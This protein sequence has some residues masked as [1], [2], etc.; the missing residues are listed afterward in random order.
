MFDV[1]F[2]GGAIL[3][4][5]FLVVFCILMADGGTRAMAARGPRRRGKTAWLTIVALSIGTAVIMSSLGVGDALKGLVIARADLNLSGVDV[6]VISAD[7]IDAGHIDELRADPQVASLCKDLEPAFVLPVVLHNNV[8]GRTTARAILYAFDPQMGDRLGTFHWA[9]NGSDKSGMPLSDGQVVLNSK[10]AKEVDAFRH[11]D[12]YIG[13]D[14]PALRKETMFTDPGVDHVTMPIGQI[15]D[16][17]GLGRF[18]FNVQD[19]QPAAYMTLHTVR[20]ALKVGNKMNAVLVS[21]KEADEANNAKI[22]IE[23]ALDASLQAPDLHLKVATVPGDKAI[24]SHVQVSSDRVFFKES[25]LTGLDGQRSLISTYFVDTLSVEHSKGSVSY[26]SY[27]TVTGLVPS[28]DANFG[29]FTQNGTH[30]QFSGDLQTG[31]IGITNWTAAM[32]GAKVGDT[33]II[34]YSI[35]DD[36]FDLIKHNRSFTV[37]WVVDMVGKANDTNLMPNFPGIGGIESCF[38]WNPPFPIDLSSIQPQDESY[39]KQFKG[40]P[41]AY[42]LLPDA[43][44][45]WGN[46]QGNVTMVKTVQT[47]NIVS[48]FLDT[49]ATTATVGMSVAALRDQLVRSA[50]AMDIF[51]QMFL[52]FGAITIAAAIIFVASTFRMMVDERK[53]E[54]GMMR[55]LGISRNRI[56][57]DM[58]AEGLLYSL[59]GGLLGLVFGLI[60]AGSLLVG[61]QTVWTSVVGGQQVAAQ[62]FVPIFMTA[63]TLAMS[64]GAGLLLSLVCLAVLA[65]TGSRMTIMESRGHTNDT[66]KPND[67]L[68]MALVGIVVVLFI[69]I[70]IAPFVIPGKTLAF[71]LELKILI[72]MTWVGAFFFWAK[73]KSVDRPRKKRSLFQGNGMVFVMGLGLVATVISIISAAGEFSNPPISVLALFVLDGLLITGSLFLVFVPILWLLPKAPTRTSQIVALSFMKRNGKRTAMTIGVFALIIF[74]IISLSVIIQ[75]EN[76]A[77][78]SSAKQQGGGFDVMA[79]ATRPIGPDLNDK[80][81]RAKLGVNLTVPADFYMVRTVGTSG[82]VCSNMNPQ[83]PPRLMGVDDRFVNASSLSLTSSSFSGNDKAKWGSLKTKVDGRIPIF[84]D[85][86]TLI[87]Y[88]GYA[89]YEGALGHVFKVDT[90]KGQAELVVAGILS[91]SIIAGNFV[92]HEDYLKQLYPT[93]SGYRVVFVKTP[94]K[95]ALI[96]ELEKGLANFGLDARSV[97]DIVRES[98]SAE[99][100]YMNLFQA[101]LGAGLGL[102]VVALAVTQARE[103]VERRRDIAMLKAIGLSRTSI[104][105]VFYIEAAFVGLISLGIGLIAGLALAFTSGPAWGLSAGA[106]VV[107]PYQFM[108]LFSAGLMGILLLAT[109]VP[110]TRASRLSPVSVLKEE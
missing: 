43:E 59:I 8:S 110:A 69:L 19:V 77:L 104:G 91:P 90:E 34:T 20:D 62:A 70:L 5:I 56:F 49:K 28:D 52:A 14:S 93:G 31:Q 22:A 12:L 48:G 58:L 53:A 50:S 32:L 44:A 108:V 23:T 47:A 102:G 83:Y 3:I 80:A 29:A 71:S 38:K 4:A 21:L 97:E 9:D 51:L 45:M 106:M 46:D 18:Q 101:Y 33:L 76:S 73:G 17:D 75:V 57:K 42:I 40:I 27:S 54:L 89:A 98:T 96:S 64:L 107:L 67:P 87:I 65:W 72:M 1:I 66:N 26:L 7:F 85:E 81:A 86:N 78:G 61:L 25:L 79:E 60:A 30:Q 11:E 39:W 10:A 84:V 68:M 92:M 6:V 74:S 105:M 95:D 55:S 2:I 15:V 13:L 94:N 82:A 35:M 100:G 109:A 41:K 16:N 88:L 24:P 103:V 36:H 63:G 99:Q 37:A